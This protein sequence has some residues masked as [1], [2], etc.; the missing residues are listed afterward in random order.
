MSERKK[1]SAKRAQKHP[2]YSLKVKVEGPGIHRKSIPVPDLLKICSAIQSAVHRQAEVMVRPEARTLRR[3]PITATAQDECTLELTGI[4]GG[5]TGLVFRFAKPQQALPIPGAPTFG[6][7]VLARV[8]QTVRE[9]ESKREPSDVD[10]GVLAS[11]QELGTALERHTISKI[12]LSVPHHNGKRRQ[13]KAAYTPAVRERIA[14]RMKAPT[15]E[16]R[17]IEGKLEMADFKETGRVCR[18]HPSIGVPVQCTFDPGKED[19]I[20]DALRKPARVT[21]TANLNPHTGRVEELKIEEIEILDELLVG[22]RN[23][24]AGHTLAQLAEMQGVHALLNPGELAGGWPAD[25]SV[26]EFIDATY[27]TRS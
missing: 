13:I 18:I 7:E 19:E 25:E 11:L 22:S 26:D 14:A 6:S 24:F 21:G 20:Y 16:R 1:T 9:F 10:P 27:A 3:G 15:Q 8:A 17:S 23:F 12:F 5:S 2:G 4:V